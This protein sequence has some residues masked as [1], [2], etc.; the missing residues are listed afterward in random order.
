[1]SLQDAFLADIIANPDDD[2]VRLIYADW[3]DEHDQPARAEFI[4]LQIA[5]GATHA[6]NRR[7]TLDRRERQLLAEHG[8]EWA[9]E[10]REFLV[11]WEFRRGFIEEVS[12]LPEPFLTGEERLFRLSPVRYLKL[13]P[14]YERTTAEVARFMQRFSESPHLDRLVELDC[15]HL[16]M[17]SDGLKALAVSPGF[18]Q[19]WRLNLRDNFISDAGMRAL[20]EAS[21]LSCLCELNLRQNDITPR[22]VRALAAALAERVRGHEVFVLESVDLRDNPL[23]AAGARAVAASPLLGRIARL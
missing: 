15:T 4:R 13:L 12:A 16:R 21:W 22:G 7:L 6:Q 23:R 20:G 14:E 19:L 1:M 10:L 5:T 11:S 17:G 2:A 8:D 18:T 9:G 3:L